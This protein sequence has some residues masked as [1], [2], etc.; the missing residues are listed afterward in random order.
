MEHTLRGNR[1]FAGQV[2]P[3]L[4]LP[5]AP[6]SAILKPTG[7]RVSIAQQFGVGVGHEQG[8]AALESTSYRGL[9]RTIG[10]TTAP[11][12]SQLQVGELR[13]RAIKLPSEYCGSLPRPVADR[14]IGSY[15]WIH[16]FLVDRD[17]FSSSCLYRG[18]G[19]VRVRYLIGIDIGVVVRKVNAM[20]TC[21]GNVGEKTA[22]QLALNVEIILLHVSCFRVGVR[23][24]IG[25]AVR[26]DKV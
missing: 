10:A 21:E 3:V 23:R 26:G 12:L 2:V 11:I 14:E 7:L 5:H 13:E 17:R 24:Q 4:H 19:N 9:Q 6:R 18:L 15:H 22:R 1:F 8:T 16:D 20:R 25:R